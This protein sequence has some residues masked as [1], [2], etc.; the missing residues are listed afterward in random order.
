[1]DEGKK[2]GKSRGGRKVEEGRGG[3]GRE[4]EGR[5]GRQ[6]EGRREAPHLDHGDHMV[7]VQQLRAGVR[8][9]HDHLGP[10]FAPN[11]V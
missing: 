3:G 10:G 9:R 5:K 8:R 1:M 2:E 11:T 7:V 6:E 4:E